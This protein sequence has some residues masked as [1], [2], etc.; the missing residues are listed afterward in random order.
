MLN[1]NQLLPGDI[2]R[3]PKSFRDHWGIVLRSGLVLD[4]APGRGLRESTPSTFAAG[5]TINVYRPSRDTVPV[6]LKRAESLVG[7][8]LKYSWILSNCEHVKNYALEGRWHSETITFIALGILAT[9]AVFT[10][11]RASR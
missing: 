11:T 10:G 2:L 6:V 9:V 1:T 8:D 7:T 3:R 4:I 5:Q